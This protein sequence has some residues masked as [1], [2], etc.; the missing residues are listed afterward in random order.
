MLTASLMVN[1]LSH[2][3]P[4]PSKAPASGTTSGKTDA[5]HIVIRSGS[6]LKEIFTYFPR[7][8]LPNEHNI[9]KISGSGAYRLTVD[10]QGNVTEI[11]ILKRMGAAGDS[12]ADVAALKTFFAWRGK[13]GPI[14]IVDVTWGSR[15]APL[16]INRDSSHIP[17][18]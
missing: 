16:F 15:V 18:R 2:A 5:V 3:S 17:R 7:P 4:Q 10:R 8:I 9:L 14:R 12:R 11:K 6:D 1:G 13:P